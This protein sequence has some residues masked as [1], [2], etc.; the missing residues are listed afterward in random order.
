M[1]FLFSESI[2]LWFNLDM[3]GFKSPLSDQ[4]YSGMNS[5]SA[6]ISSELTFATTPAAMTVSY[7]AKFQCILSLDN[8]TGAYVSSV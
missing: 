8:T 1:K 5:Q 4:F 7:F 2:I 3:D 6:S